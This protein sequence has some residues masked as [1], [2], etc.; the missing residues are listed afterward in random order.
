MT[1]HI[2][3]NR[4][5]IICCYNQFNIYFF[6]YNY[7]IT[8]SQSK[9]EYLV[10]TDLKNQMFV[11]LCIFF[12]FEPQLLIHFL[13]WY[14]FVQQ[15]IV[16]PNAMMLYHKKVCVS[17]IWFYLILRYIIITF[18]KVFCEGKRGFSFAKT[19]K[20]NKIQHYMMLQNRNWLISYID[21]QQY[22]YTLIVKYFFFIYQS[23]NIFYLLKNS[24]ISVKNTFI[25]GAQY[26]WKQ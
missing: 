24:T 4:G 9:T 10:K 11:F 6:K 14:Y 25:W 23:I 19:I 17:Q 13:N 18:K 2:F 16:C 5:I 7:I 20:I 8:G 1:Q 15:N 26:K 22:Y 21:T 12:P 3:W